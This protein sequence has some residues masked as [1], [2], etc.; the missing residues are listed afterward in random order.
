[1]LRTFPKFEYGAELRPPRNS[2]PGT[3]K[4]GRHHDK[5]F[6]FGFSDSGMMID[7]LVIGAAI[8]FR[9]AELCPETV[10]CLVGTPR[11]GKKFEG[12]LVAF[13]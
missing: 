6:L 11:V 9:G 8:G 5:T 10:G 4:E 3:I 1:M 13:L 2:T 7:E 12:L